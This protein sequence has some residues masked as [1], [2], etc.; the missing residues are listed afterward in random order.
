MSYSFWRSSEIKLLR[1]NYRMMP[2]AELAAA[3][4]RHSPAAID[5][6]ASRLGIVKYT[7]RDWR[8]IAAA[9]VPVIFSAGR[10][11]E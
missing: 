1:S 7:R 3:L 4:P 5:R 6:M 11:A 8:A 9:H 2:R 10:A